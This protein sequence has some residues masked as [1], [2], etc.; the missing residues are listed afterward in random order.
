M[1]P[2]FS[3]DFRQRYKNVSMR[4]LDSVS[5]LPRSFTIGIMCTKTRFGVATEFIVQECLGKLK[6]QSKKKKGWD[7]FA[8]TMLP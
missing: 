6:V 1:L 8:F 3:K 2:V 4:L 5:L 7:K